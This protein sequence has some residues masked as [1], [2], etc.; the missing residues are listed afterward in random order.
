M[1][2]ISRMMDGSIPYDPENRLQPVPSGPGARQEDKIERIKEVPIF[3]GCSERQ[4]LSVA[5]IAWIFDVAANTVLARAGDPG[6][7]F[8]LIMDGSARVEVSPDKRLLLRPGEFFGEMSMLDGSPRSAT[9]VAETPVRLLVISRQHF[10]VLLTE[11]PGLTQT[12]LVTLSRRVRQ[13]EAQ[14][15]QLRAASTGL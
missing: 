14:V 15:E 11:V 1:E 10:S 6:D 3:Q 9:V 12:L 5:K 2:L 4:L 13:A 7:Q 8:F